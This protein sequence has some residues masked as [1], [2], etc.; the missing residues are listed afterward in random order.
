MTT[1]ISMP[2]WTSGSG[3]QP[4]FDDPHG[5][6]PS[7]SA[8]RRSRHGIN[9]SNAR[10]RCGASASCRNTKTPREL[11]RISD[12]KP[13]I[14]RLPRNLTISPYLKIKAPA[15]LTIDMRT[16]NYKGG[17]EY[18]YRAEYVTRDGVQEFESLAVSQWPLDDLFAFP[19]AWKSSTCVIARRDTIPISWAA[20]SA[21]I[22]S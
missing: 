8:S 15:G 20:L 12:G 9:S 10:F 11:P 2:G 13:I 1:F 21:M 6:P 4:D 18:N 19:P 16:D 22:R 17:S 14:A 7:P 3:R 5:R